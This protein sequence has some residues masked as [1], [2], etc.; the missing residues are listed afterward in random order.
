MSRDSFR[1]Q[2]FNGVSVHC[3]NIVEYLVKMLDRGN[4]E[5]LILATTFLKKLSI[6]QESKD[7]MVQVKPKFQ[8][9]AKKARIK[10]LQSNY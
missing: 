9:K 3:Q 5:L 7:R 4:I 8:L 6:Y 10:Q 1:R 2:L